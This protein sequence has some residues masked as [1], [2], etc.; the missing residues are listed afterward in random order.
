MSNAGL[1]VCGTVSLELSRPDA[2]SAIGPD[3]PEDKDDDRNDSYWYLDSALQ[4]FHVVSPPISRRVGF[5]Y[6][7]MKRIPWGKQRCTVRVPSHDADRG[8]I[9]SPSRCRFRSSWSA[10]R[11][12]L[13]DR[14]DSDRPG[15]VLMMG[16]F[17]ELSE[18]LCCPGPPP[19]LDCVCRPVSASGW[20]MYVGR[21]QSTVGVEDAACLGRRTHF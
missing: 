14:D 17:G 5:T 4:S 11:N 15:A 8:P 19:A 10:G 6:Q 12:I 13:I 1:G 16:D 2:R 9:F 18:G 21:A 3:H 20:L 7:K